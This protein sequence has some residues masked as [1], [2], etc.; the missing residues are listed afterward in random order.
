MKRYLYLLFCIITSIITIGVIV[1]AFYQYHEHREIF[2]WWTSLLYWI[3]ETV[4]LSFAF[5][6]NV[7]FWVYYF[8]DTNDRDKEIKKELSR[9]LKQNKR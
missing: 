3:I 9:L 8:T 5:M 2:V 1:H 6:Y 4:A 7:L